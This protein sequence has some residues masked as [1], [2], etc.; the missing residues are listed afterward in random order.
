MVA[1]AEED[2]EVVFQ[3]QAMMAYQHQ[4]ED[5]VD[6]VVVQEIMVQLAH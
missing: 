1:V 4:K 6:A 5:L 2:M 3:H